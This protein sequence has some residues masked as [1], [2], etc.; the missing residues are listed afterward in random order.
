MLVLPLATILFAAGV[1]TPQNYAQNTRLVTN[2]TGR[3]AGDKDAKLMHHLQ[4]D[5]L[6]F[7]YGF[8]C[9]IAPCDLYYPYPDPNHTQCVVYKVSVQ[10]S[11]DPRKAKEGPFISNGCASCFDDFSAC[12]QKSCSKVFQPC[13]W[14]KNSQE[15][16]TCASKQCLPAFKPCVGIHEPFYGPISADPVCAI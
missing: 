10:T 2:T 6:D 7:G 1:P 9:V 16:M 5:A 3:C 13:W 4:Y 14:D 15:C 11:R 8:A 12:H